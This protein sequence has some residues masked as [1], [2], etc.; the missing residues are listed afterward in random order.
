MVRTTRDP[1]LPGLSPGGNTGAYT[2][3]LE[4]SAS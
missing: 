3:T 1:H 2:L 4:G